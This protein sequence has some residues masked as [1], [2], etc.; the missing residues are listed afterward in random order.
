M[1]SGPLAE[2]SGRLTNERS[3]AVDAEE[4]AAILEAEGLTDDQ[5]R[6]RYGEAGLFALAEQLY[7]QERRA[8]AGRPVLVQR[9][10]FPWRLTLRG[11][12]YLLPAV[13][14]LL[15]ARLAPPA[16]R[17]ALNLALGLASAFGWGWSMAVARL[18]FLDPLGV[19]GR[20]L[21]QAALLGLPL[22]LLLGTLG[23][24]MAGLSLPQ[25]LLGAL[26]CGIFSL[27][28]GVAGAL[29]SLDRR[30]A[31]L[32]AFVPA[33]LVAGALPLLHGPW[34][35][36]S[37][38]LGLGLIALLPLVTLM[39]Q[40]RRP[41]HRGERRLDRAALRLAI[42]QALYG[43]SVAAFFGL[44][45]L[46]LGSGA[47][48]LPTVLSVGLLEG[49]VWHFQHRLQHQVRHASVPQPLRGLWPLLR[50][51]A[52]YF[53]LL[54]TLQLLTQQLG[55]GSAPLALPLCSAA[56]LPSAWL[57]SQGRLRAVTLLWLLGA[58]TLLWPPAAAPPD[59]AMTAVLLL[60]CALLLLCWTA[61]HDLRAYR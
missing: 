56:F 36:P 41:E 57:A 37:L 12:L 1:R 8:R 27:A 58:A 10:T 2:L 19:P 3:R 9:P 24:L 39:L 42:P 13:S 21:L 44:M 25:L 28:L 55:L 45:A 33:L 52:I 5:A 7:A 6:S 32:V 18:R 40:F 47:V 20:L 22:G 14:L 11:P 54:G 17:E 59:P 48:L 23:A 31:T 26:A 15:T 30:Q 49:L 61:L 34:L 35:L 53:A 16:D 38:P 51:S 4:L 60:P 43:W 50:L 46:R 29:I